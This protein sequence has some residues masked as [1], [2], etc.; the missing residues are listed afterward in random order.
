MRALTIRL[1]ALFCLL[2]PLTTAGCGD[3]ADDGHDDQDD[4]DDH[5]AQGDDKSASAAGSGSGDQV[6]AVREERMCPQFEACGGDPE[7]TWTVQDVCLNNGRELFASTIGAACADAYRAASVEGEGSYELAEGQA[8]SE[9]NLNT[10]VVLAF[11]D[12]CIQSILGKS[13]TAASQCANLARAL[14]ADPNFASVA[15]EVEDA[16]CVCELAAPEVTSGEDGAYQ[17]RDNELVIDGKPVP[18]CIDGD[19]MTIKPT[20]E[21]ATVTITLAK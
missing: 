2:C 20:I 15:C 17:V 19:T 12:S 21:G 7:G 6:D 3:D 8:S 18:F 14:S 5:D 9:F 4:H 1:A 11:D 16:D 10:S 13:A